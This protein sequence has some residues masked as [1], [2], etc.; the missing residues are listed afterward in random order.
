LHYEYDYGNTLKIALKGYFNTL[1]RRKVG[2][3]IIGK[4]HQ[5]EPIYV[6]GSQGLIERNSVR[7][8]FSII[9]YLSS[10]GFDET[11]RFDK[12]LNH[13]YE[14]VNHYPKQLHELSWKEYTANKK[15][16]YKNQIMLQ[17][18]ITNNN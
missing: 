3:T 5:G 13:W 12:R 16:E 2:F 7:Y 10:I 6:K 4:N 14:S 11:L 17:N 9:S 1:G 8:Y 15:K 18:M